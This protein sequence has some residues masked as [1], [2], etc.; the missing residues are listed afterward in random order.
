[1]ARDA[2]LSIGE[3]ASHAA[4][5]TALRKM[6]PDATKLLE[7]DHREVESF[8]DAY[9]GLKGGVAKQRMRE[10]ICMLLKAHMQVEEEIFYPQ[11][12]AAI[13]QDGMVD[14]AMEEHTDAK[15]LIGEIEGAAGSDDLD[16]S[17]EALRESIKK[18]VCEE[19]MQLFPEV[20]ETDM[21]LYGLGGAMAALRIGLLRDLRASAML[22][23]ESDS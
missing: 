4:I 22:Q 15:R 18:H 2:E 11:A 3:V 9:T 14:H 23:S 16:A 7:Q 13:G 21:D 5:F 19:E 10:T 1:M 6:P 8:F 17:V 12:R 20:R